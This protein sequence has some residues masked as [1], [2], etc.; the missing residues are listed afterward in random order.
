MQK[1][2]L[3]LTAVLVAGLSFADMT[4]VTQED[5]AVTFAGNVTVTSNLTAT[6]GLTL[7]GTSLTG[8][9]GI[10]ATGAVTIGEGKLA[11]DTIVEADLKAVDSANDEDFLSYE[12]TTGDFEWH[13]ASEIAGKLSSLNATN[14]IISGDS[15]TN[16]ITVI[17]G[18]ITAWT[19]AP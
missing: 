15:K 14:T 18:V 11:N 3:G 12:S 9:N 7:T 8:L 6:A 2:A 16:V 17:N 13:S 10:T 19:V 5:P 4:P 1:F